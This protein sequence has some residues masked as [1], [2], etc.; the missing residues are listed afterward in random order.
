MTISEI[1]NIITNGKS[2]K[3]WFSSFNG[4]YQLVQMDGDKLPAVDGSQLINL[5]KEDP[6]DD[7]FGAITNT[8]DFSGS[9]KQIIV[10]DAD[11]TVTILNPQANEVRSLH[12]FHGSSAQTLIINGK[13]FT[14]AANP[15]GQKVVSVIIAEKI[16][17]EIYISDSPET[18]SLSIVQQYKFS[19]SAQNISVANS[20][21]FALSGAFSVGFLV[22][23]TATGGQFLIGRS[24]GSTRIWDIAFSPDTDGLR[25]R[26]QIRSSNGA[27]KFSKGNAKTLNV[28]YHVVVTWSGV[29]TDSLAVYINGFQEN[30]LTNTGTFTSLPTGGTFSIGSF[31]G[32]NS[33]DVKIS[34]LFI[35]N[36]T[37]LTQAQVTEAYNSGS[38]LDLTVASFYSSVTDYWKLNSS[39]NSVKGTHNGTAT[40][41]QYV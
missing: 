13:S 20:S 26:A 15:S 38:T 6:L 25:V 4:S 27:I 10:M 9:T 22:T 23:Q 30:T 21:D 19:T 2:I 7:T 35:C 24:N 40:T 12:V 29:S 36:S 39:L 33:K 41:P 5:P 11:K 16:N 32:L 37:Q 28:T 14:I 3:N 1:L 8:W 31:I 34:E 18:F 17:T